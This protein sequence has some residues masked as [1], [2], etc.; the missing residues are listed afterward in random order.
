MLI[1]EGGELLREWVLILGA[2][3]EWVGNGLRKVYF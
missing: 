2:K 3:F 1:G